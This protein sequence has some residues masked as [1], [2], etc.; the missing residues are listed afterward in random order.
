MLAKLVRELP[1]GEGL[2]YEPKWDGF[3][4]ISYLHEGSLDMRSRH[5]RPLA[6]YFPEIAAALGRIPAERAVID[7]EI[8]IAREQGLD[9]AAL[10]QRLHPAA[11]RVE[12]LSKETPAIFIA[13]DLI[14][15][16]DDDLSRISFVERRRLLER[17][18]EPTANV[19][20]TPSTRD[21]AVARAW[22]DEFAGSGL[23]GVVVKD[24]ALPYLPGKRAMTKVKRELTADC[25]VAGFRWHHA[26]RAVGS[27]LLGLYVDGRLRHVGLAS[28]FP[29]K[30]RRELVEEVAP[31]VTELGGH[32]WEHGFNLAPGPVGRLPGVASRWAEGG[33]ITWVPLRPELVC[34]VSYDHWDV[35]RF[36]HPPRFKTWR[37]DRDPRS[38][39]LSQFPQP[40]RPIDEV[41]RAHT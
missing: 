36:R 20:V 1:V 35:D 19:I 31:Y 38:C 9:F 12:L 26:E 23:D 29:A 11:S 7:G 14:G 16:Q 2:S 33:E 10:L 32:P 24:D 39:D 6:R 37:R 25:V 4:C 8:V 15:L 27:L 5:G 34:E 41:L 28:S 22:L 21:A 40:A 13:F 3:R 17:V 18:V 30:R